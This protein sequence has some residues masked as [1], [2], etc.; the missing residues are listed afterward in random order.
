MDMPESLGML[1]RDCDYLLILD[2]EGAIEKQHLL[3]GLELQ[4]DDGQFRVWQRRQEQR[5]A[6]F[7]EDPVWHYREFYHYGARTEK[8]ECLG[9]L[10]ILVGEPF[11]MRYTDHLIGYTAS[12]D[13]VRV[14]LREG[15]TEIISTAFVLRPVKPTGAE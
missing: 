1:M 11:I 9:E 2:D 14:D 10:W 6:V 5:I 4:W 7:F 13:T 3:S 15:K 8:A 12:R